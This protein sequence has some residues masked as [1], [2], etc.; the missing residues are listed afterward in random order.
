MKMYENILKKVEIYEEKRGIS[1]TKPGGKLYK[2]VNVI[3]WLAFIYTMAM[4]VLFSL[5]IAISDTQFHYL[6]NSLYTVL[7]LCVGLILA[8]VLT[9]FKKSIVSAVSSVINALSCAGLV[10]AFAPLMEN[11]A[12]GYK[13]AFYWRHFAPLCIVLLVNLGLNIIVIRANVK[14]RKTYKKIVDNIYSTYHTNI[15]DGE[16]DEKEWDEVLKN[17]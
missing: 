15:A 17:I 9:L 3:Y 13:G 7:G 6:K 2:Y 1:Y 10:L 5:G 11:V 4:N 8:R 16:L 14:T 12:G